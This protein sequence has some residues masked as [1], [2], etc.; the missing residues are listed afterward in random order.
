M[1]G[2]RRLLAFFV[3]IF[4]AFLSALSGI[5]G[6]VACQAGNTG[7]RSRAARATAGGK[8]IVV[9]L[10]SGRKSM[11][12]SSSKTENHSSLDL[13]DV[14]SEY[15]SSSRAYTLAV[16]RHPHLWKSEDSHSCDVIPARCEY[17][18]IPSYPHFV[19]HTGCARYCSLHC[20]CRSPGRL[21]SRAFSGALLASLFYTP[22]LCQHSSLHIYSPCGRT[23]DHRAYVA[24]PRHR[25]CLWRSVRYLCTRWKRGFS[26]AYLPFRCVLDHM[27]NVCTS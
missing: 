8:I 4:I 3:T 26:G 10:Q 18:G 7:D 24:C 14:S 1:Q 15:E 2:I 16:H 20:F 23:F 25:T 22:V 12:M 6:L 27:R 9:I 21:P 19:S 11:H 17:V 5:L 13:H